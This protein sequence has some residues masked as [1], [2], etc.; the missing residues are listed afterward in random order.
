MHF[1]LM[2]SNFELILR[3]SFFVGISFLSCI[4][5]DEKGL[6]GLRINALSLVLA[7]LILILCF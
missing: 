6:S 4:T 2:S 5:E 3:I 7:G 1:D